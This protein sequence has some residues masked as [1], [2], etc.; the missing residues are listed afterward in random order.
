[1]PMPLQSFY[2]CVKPILPRAVSG[3]FSKNRKYIFPEQ[4]KFKEHAQDDERPSKESGHVRPSYGDSGS[5]Y[6]IPAEI[7]EPISKNRAPLSPYKATI[8][9]IHSSKVG[10]KNEVP[11]YSEDGKEQCTIKVTKLTDDIIKWVKE[12]SGILK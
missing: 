2:K 1:M 12:R 4:L 6:W 10:P 11:K 7:F 3:I 5:P 9:A 8:V